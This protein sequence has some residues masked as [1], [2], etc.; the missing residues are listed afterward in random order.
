MNKSHTKESW[1]AYMREYRIRRPDRVKHSDL[2][3]KFGIS[4]EEYQN[5]MTEQNEVC[6]LCAKPES[7]VD[8]RTKKVTSLAVDHC[9]TSGKVRGLLCSSCNT[10][11]GLLKEDVELLL[12][13]IDYIKSNQTRN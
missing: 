10:A 7:R 8:H 2:R 6:K 5:M 11:L 4:F 9:H 12:K 1:A 3:K 13:A